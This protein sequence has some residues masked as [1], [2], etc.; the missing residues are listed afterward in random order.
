M[1]RYNFI[2]YEK[3][4]SSILDELKTLE[5]IEKNYYQMIKLK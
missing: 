5:Y 2:D 3:L 1:T 4:C